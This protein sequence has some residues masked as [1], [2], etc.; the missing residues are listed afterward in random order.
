M[1]MRLGVIGLGGAGLKHCRSA[2]SLPTI[3]LVATADPNT[4]AEL[5]LPAATRRYDDWRRIIDDPRVQAI[6]VCVPHHLH[7]EIAIAAMQ[8]GKHVL[9]EKPI[10]S[11]LEQAEQ[12]VLAAQNTDVVLMVEMTHRFYPPLIEARQFIAGGRLGRILAAEDRIIEPGAEHLPAW[13]L[14]SE[15][16]GGGVALTNGV[17]MLDRVA[18][19]CGEPLRLHCGRVSRNQQLG[20][21]EDTAMMHLSLAGDATPV[22]VLASWVRRGTHLDDELTIYATG[23]TLRVWAWHGWRFEPRDGAHEE[24]ETYPATDSLD[25][26]VAVGMRAALAAFADAIVTEAE[27]PVPVEDALSAQRL[28]HQL[29]QASR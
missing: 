28:I 12:V 7:A 5:V 1:K 23:G 8:A 17:H 6:S 19:M 9:L 4:P 10:A 29:Y 16:A 18:W 13:M 14:R 20:D 2:A 26:R 15:T 27:S 3:E 25:D 22:S 11:N 21:V 24:Y